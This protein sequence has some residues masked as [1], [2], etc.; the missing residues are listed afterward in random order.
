VVARVVLLVGYGGPPRHP[1]LDVN[2]YLE[3]ALNL[4]RD[5]TYG[6][7]VSTDY[8][9]L[10][11][12]LVAPTFA[13]SSNDLRFAI[14][15]GAHAL[16]LAGASLTLLPM[17]RSAMSERSAWLTL[18]AAQFLAGAGYHAL[19]ARSEALLMALF[20]AATG[21]VWWALD[22]PSSRRWF[23]VGVLCGLAVACRRTGL[24]VPAAATIVALMHPGRGRAVLAL[25][26]GTAIGLG[27]EVAAA[28]LHG[29]TLRTYHDG[30]VAS[31]LSAVTRMW[32][33]PER[34]DLAVSTAARQLVY[35]LVAFAG[36]PLVLL[37][38]ARRRAE[39]PRPLA[40]ASA[41]ALLGLLGLAALST[42]HILRYA[43]GRPDA[44]AWHVYPRYLDPAETAV[45]L[46]AVAVAAHRRDAHPWSAWWF[47]PA[48]LVV[49]PAV[50]TTR[51][52][53]S[54]VAPLR[55]FEGT[56]L[57]SWYPYLLAVLAGAV[58]IALVLARGRYGRASTV[59]AA[60]G[61]GWMISFHFVGDVDRWSRATPV[62]PILRT[63]AVAAAPDAPLAVLVRRRPIHKRE[64]Y[65]PGFRSDHDVYWVPLRE[66][67]AWLEAH[68]DGFVLTRTFERA[69][70]HRLG[71]TLSAATKRWAVWGRVAPP[72]DAPGE[73]SVPSP[74]R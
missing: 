67:P 13:L 51:F 59:V 64:L 61:L 68:P 38:W 52:R 25:A 49:L 1:R 14:I 47:V 4:W 37:G 17:L 34:I 9:P 10:Y 57:E 20:C 16:L 21:A 35:P 45:I 12:F 70:G 6:S 32:A 26:A 48:A 31:H 65:G 11:P 15:Y 30:V 18:A 29:G 28:W 33:T 46:C 42:L 55:L 72:L 22:R 36:A 19:W 24:V 58:L 54:R 60:V 3:L 23:V 69:P 66:I 40:G 71:L 50:P 8:P 5:G 63:A 53:G 44:E 41:F 74:D 2:N 73:G 7:V 43:Y 62:P 56:P 27:P 39:L